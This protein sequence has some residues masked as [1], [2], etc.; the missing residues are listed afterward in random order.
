MDSIQGDKGN[1]WHSIIMFKNCVS[2]KGK[3]LVSYAHNMCMLSN[4]APELLL[5]FPYVECSA[6]AEHHVY[7]AASLAIGKMGRWEH[8]PI[9]EQKAL[10]PSNKGAVRALA[11]GECSPC[12][13][14]LFSRFLSE[15]A[16]DKSVLDIDMALRKEIAGV[17]G[18]KCW[19]LGSSVRSDQCRWK[20]SRICLC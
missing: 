14:V 2:T 8:L 6:L 11:A 3:I 5:C 4:A 10:S 13:A 9:G 16:L 20:M 19:I 7:Y 1:F 17:L 15:F 18:T 12:Q